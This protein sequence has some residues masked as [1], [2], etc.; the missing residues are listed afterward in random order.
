M[1]L[2]AYECIASKGEL[3]E[4]TYANALVVTE[5]CPLHPPLTQTQ[6]VQASVCK[7]DLDGFGG[8]GMGDHLE[9]SS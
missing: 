8:L 4:N 2:G 3:C 9:A 5:A 7:V 6:R 1:E